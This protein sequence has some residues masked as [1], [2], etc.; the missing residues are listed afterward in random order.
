MFL[1]IPN[2]LSGFISGEIPSAY[3]LRAHAEAL[4]GIEPIQYDCCVNSHICYVGHYKCLDKCPECNEPRF[5]GHNSCGNPRPRRQ[6][7][8]IPLIP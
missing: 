1:A 7:L 2:G 5:S 4:A 6:F 8:Y 3:L